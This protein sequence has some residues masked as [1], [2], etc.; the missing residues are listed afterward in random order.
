MVF[1]LFWGDFFMN[2]Q[3]LG[4]DQSSHSYWIYGEESTNSANLSPEELRE[5]ILAEDKKKRR[6]LLFFSC[7]TLSLIGTMIILSGL[8]PNLI[9][10]PSLVDNID[11][12]SSNEEIHFYNRMEF[13]QWLDLAVA[14]K[15]Q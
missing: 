11:L 9:K 14:E 7:L 2:S 8:K 12:L 6:R 1:L 15:A 13:Y 10:D 5:K 4:A 3:D